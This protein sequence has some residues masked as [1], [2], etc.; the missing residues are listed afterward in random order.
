MQNG[1]TVLPFYNFA[2]LII[3]RKLFYLGGLGGVLGLGG[4]LGFLGFFGL[5]NLWGFGGG[6]GF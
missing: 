1:K 5:G 6:L 3:S 2:L 4:G